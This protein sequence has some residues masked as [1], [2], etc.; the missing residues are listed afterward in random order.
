MNLRLHLGEMKET[1]DMEKAVCNHGFFMMA[2]NVWNP[3]SKSLHRPLTLSDSSSTDVTI[4]HPSGLSFLVIQ[5]HGINN[6][7][8]VDEALILQQVARM[9]RLSDKDERDMVEFQQVH[10]AARKSGFGRIFRSPSLFED[11]VKSILLCN[12]DWGKTLLMASRLCKLQSKLADGTVRPLSVS[13]KRKLNPK[14]W[15]AANGNFPSAKEIAS[16]DK[17]VINEHCKLG[18]RANQIVNLAK[19]VENGSL[20]LEKMEKGE[21]EVDEVVGKLKKLKGFGP[22][23]SATVLM[24]MGYYHL[25]PSDTET[26]RL[27]REVHENEECSKETLEKAAQSF[28]DRFSPFQC[29]A[30]WFDLIQNYE[31]KLGKLSK[32]SPSDYNSVSGCCHMKQL[33]AN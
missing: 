27:L 26:L 15:M 23:A 4:S 32:L 1:F 19:K 10:E 14:P 18:Y 16:L 28:Y 3:S 22:F 33:K 12:S 31:T 20:N 11:M 13:K 29:L 9:L 24:C 8:R 17:D 7:S 6:V 5:V 30:Y 2:P 21:M 25:V